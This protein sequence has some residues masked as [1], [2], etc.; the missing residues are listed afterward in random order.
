[1]GEF[2]FLHAADIHLDSPMRGLEA[3]PD[4]PAALLREASRTA[5]RNLIDVAIEEQVAFVLIAGD[6]YDGNWQDY[7]TGLFFVEQVAKLAEAGIPLV[8]IRGNHDAQSVITRH[9]RLPAHV[10]LLPYDRCG[11]VVLEEHGVAVHGQSFATPAVTEDL[12]SYYPPPFPGLFNIGLLHTSLNGRPRHGNYA[13]TT[14]E[15]LVAKGYDYWALGHVHAREIV[16]EDPWVVHPG[17]LQGRRIRES[18]A[19]GATFVTVRDGQ[20]S[21]VE[22]RPLD[23]VRWCSIA[24]R[25]AAESELDR[26]MARVGQALAGALE[27]AE[28]RPIAAR[29]T[30]TGATRLHGQLLGQLDRIREGV[31][32]EGRQYGAD[33]VWVESVKIETQSTD[34]FDGLDQRPDVIGRLVKAFDE[35][36]ARSGAELLGDYAETLKQRLAGI[37]LPPEHPLRE[38]GAELLKRARGMLLA[39]LAG[40]A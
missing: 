17:N 7:R 26:V 6:L 18:G 22:H 21:A 35:L 36:I 38:G 15:T 29:V 12:S 14:A 34:D 31:I 16:H 37:G 39:R 1:M 20:I 10:T 32:A 4:A 13:P 23:T 3:D 25:L 11:R 33:A 28:D 2:R 9:L 40:E 19:K 30:L 24:I 5:F 8:M 27:A